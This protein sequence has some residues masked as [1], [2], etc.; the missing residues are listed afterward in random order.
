MR[1]VK[2]A[3]TLAGGYL[4]LTSAYILV[5]DRL[6]ATLSASVTTLQHI[7]LIK[8]LTFVSVTSI[9]LFLLTRWGAER[10]LHS[11]EEL[12]RRLDQMAQ[13]ERHAQVSLVAATVAHDLNNVLTVLWALLDEETTPGIRA[14][15][16]EDLSGVEAALDAASRLTGTLAAAGR[17]GDVETTELL[18]VGEL[19]VDSL[20]VIRAHPALAEVSVQKAIEGPLPARVDRSAVLRIL[21]N[22]VLNAAEATGPGGHIRVRAQRADGVVEVRVEDDGPGIS[23]DFVP[24]LFEPFKTTKP[25]GTGLGLVVARRCARQLGGK[26]ALEDSELGGAGFVLRLPLQR[27][28]AA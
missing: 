17:A 11:E 25:T 19:L 20:A 14:L 8:G 22:L 10:I 6:A 4:V 3:L 16:P 13:A 1:P 28:A 21:A 23:T 15:S 26:L 7:E 5:S 2:A 9:A 12:R 27:R 24:H 18:D